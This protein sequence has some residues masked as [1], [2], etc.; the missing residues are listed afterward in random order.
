MASTIHVGTPLDKD[1]ICRLNAGDP[2]LISGTVYTARDAAHQRLVQMIQSG[3][4]LP[5]P[6]EGSVIYYVGPCPPKPGHVIGPAGPTTS[7]RMD[8]Y[9]PVLLNAGMGGMIGKGNR[10][11][12]V[13]E[14]IIQHQAVYFAALGGAGALLATRIRQAEL[15][16]FPDLGPEAIYRLELDEFPAFVAID[17]LGRNIYDHIDSGGDNNGSF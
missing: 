6:L 4:P 12:R 5:I 10:S 17:A 11:Q 14:S 16:A 9:T 2:V 3:D 1:T 13:V 8:I 15:V 7:G